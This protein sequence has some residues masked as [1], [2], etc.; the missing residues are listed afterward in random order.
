MPAPGTDPVVRDEMLS[1]PAVHSPDLS[2]AEARELFQDDHLHMALLV[3]D[4]RLVAALER[5]DLAA[6]RPDDEPARAIGVPAGRTVAPD[7]P[8]DATTDAMR[9]DG[10]RR[11]AV[12]AEDGA[13]L[14]LLCLKADASGF[15]SDRGVQ[16]RRAG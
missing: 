2:F 7:T 8:L 13:L 10:R 9:R 14:G 4:G 3:E 16:G 15:C 11:L 6:P 12:V 1:R 5:G